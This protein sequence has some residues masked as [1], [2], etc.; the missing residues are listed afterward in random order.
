MSTEFLSAALAYLAAGFSPFP[1]RPFTKLPATPW[2]VFQISRATEAQLRAWF[3]ASANNIGLVLGEV[4][5]N[6]FALD[7]DDRALARQVFDLDELARVT[8]VQRTPR[9]FHVFF[10]VDGPPI[11]T[12]S[13]QGR[14][15][16]LDVKGTGGYVVAAPSRLDGAAYIRVSPDVRVATIE[17]G[18]YEALVERL[19]TRWPSI[20]V[21][22]LYS[23][24]PRARQ[25]PL[26][27]W[28]GP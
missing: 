8:L 26:S 2:K 25:R 24:P 28:W 7:F 27:E 14:G 4:S 9:G 1:L 22:P 23:A 17:A 16:P 19:L 6:A 11:Q 12:T 5:G 20:G 15:L 10:R 21:A 13:F 3:A 18:A